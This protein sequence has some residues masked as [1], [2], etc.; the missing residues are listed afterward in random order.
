MG[1]PALPAEGIAG[2][3]YNHKGGKQT[4]GWQSD[5]QI[6]PEKAVKAAG[7]KP[8][9]EQILKPLLYKAISKRKHGSYTEAE[10]QWERNWREYHFIKRDPGKGIHIHRVPD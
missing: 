5:S 3:P 9:G 10:K 7:G 8:K 6:V 1:E 4:G 2:M